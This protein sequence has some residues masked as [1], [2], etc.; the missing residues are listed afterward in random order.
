MTEQLEPTAG[1]APQ[2]DSERSR[3]SV[4]RIRAFRIVAAVTGIL[5]VFLAVSNA[6]APWGAPAADPADPQPELHRWF[7]AVSGASDFIGAVCLLAL[8]LRPRGQELLAIYFGLGIAL[9]AIVVVPFTPAFLVLLMVFVPVL[10]LY[11]YRSDLSL[12]TIMKPRPTRVSIAVAVCCAAVLL[13]IAVWALGQQIS[14]TD[15][16]ARMGIW[17]EYAEHAAGLALACVLAISGLPGRKVLRASCAVSF[18][19][20]GLVAAVVL[21]QAQASWGLA[22]GSAALAVGLFYGVSSLEGH[23]SRSAR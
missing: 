10:A 20:L 4:R 21:P 17:A 12:R 15:S 2:A 19:Y 13:A 18:L 23:H 3:P 8:A 16:A 7:T 6:L 14:G 9:A 1:S 22:G 5:F 11:P